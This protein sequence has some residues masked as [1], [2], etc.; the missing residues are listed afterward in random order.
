MRWIDKLE[1]FSAASGNGMESENHTIITNS[2]GG[3]GEGTTLV[4]M[5]ISTI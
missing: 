3:Q 4:F 1:W 2:I 5:L